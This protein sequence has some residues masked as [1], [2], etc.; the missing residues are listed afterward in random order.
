M[1][2]GECLRFGS[3]HRSDRHGRTWRYRVP[4]ALAR[5]AA[6]FP[7]RYIRNIVRSL[8]VT[9]AGDGGRDETKSDLLLLPDGFG[10]TRL[11]SDCESGTRI[12]HRAE[13]LDEDLHRC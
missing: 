9:S 7:M 8:E 2:V 12:L 4:R 10:P 11:Y 6:G 1:F 3:D 5:P 13:F